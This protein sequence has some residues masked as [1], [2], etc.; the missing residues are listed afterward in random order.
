M[1]DYQKRKNRELRKCLNRRAASSLDDFPEM[2][3]TAEAAAWFGVS[4]STIRK[5]INSGM[6]KSF[7]PAGS[8]II[9][10]KRKDCEAL[11]ESGVTG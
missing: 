3:S 8:K 9:R 5:W 2:M 6:L 4:T 10:I 11:A 1:T 7:R